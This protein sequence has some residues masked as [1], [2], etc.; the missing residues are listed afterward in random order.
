[1]K[2]SPF[3]FLGVEIDALNIPQLNALVAESIEKQQKQIIANHNLNSLYIYHHDPKMRAFYDKSDYTHI[4]GMPLVFIGKLLGHSIKREE[5]VTYADWVWSLME[6]AAQKSWR[7]FYLGSKPGV[8]EQG[9]NILRQKYPGLEIACA[10]GYIDARKDSH[11]NQATIAAI[12]AFQ[13]DILMVG[14]S[15]PRQEHWILDN[16]ELIQ[17]NAIL[18]SG[19]CMDYVAG[20]VPTP[21]RWMGRIGLEWSYRLF[22]EPKRLWKRY[23]V[24]PWFVVK[25]LIQEILGISN[26]PQTQSNLAFMSHYMATDS[27]KSDLRSA[28][29]AIIQRGFFI[30]LLRV[31]LLMLLDISSLGVAWN[32]A[33]TYASP[34]QSQWTQNLSFLLLSLAVQVAFLAT[35]G[36]YGAGVYRRDYV[37]IVK[38]VSLSSILL[39]FITFIYDPNT[40]IARS[41]FFLY[42]FLCIA[43][44][45]TVRFLF[46]LSTNFLRQKGLMRH[47]IFLIADAQQK[48]Q[49]MKIID[50]DNSYTVQG[51]AESSSLDWAN[52][53]DTFAF[54]RNQNVE[55]VLISWD[56]IKNRSFLC[57]H[58]YNAGITVHI[59]PTE[60]KLPFSKSQLSLIGGLF[61]PKIAAPIFAGFDFRIKRFFDF[62]FSLFVII[63]LSPIYLSIAVLIKLDSPGPI[64]FRQKRIGL[65][66]QEFLIWKFRTMIPNAEKVLASLEGKNEMKDGVFFK[67]KDD[68]RV[69]KVGQFLRRYS[70]DELP[71]FFNVLVGEMSLIGPRPLP[72][73]DVQKFQTKHF[74]RQE[75]LPGITGL[76]QVSGRSN[77]DNFDDV[78]KFDMNYIENWSILLDFSIFLRTFRV[79]LQK[80]GAY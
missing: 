58:F 74:I 79:I 80:T 17:T 27:L 28:K 54:L 11:E 57:W 4:D 51:F 5:R 67:M 36:L 12:N 43:G 56:S 35:T 30:R 24:Q 38:A 31:T 7:I 21:P 78:M 2:R 1:M 15:M 37:S 32:F 34:L 41:T 73:R 53:E 48:E 3:K 14:M 42:W 70:L 19:A 39:S 65:H 16:L 45:C 59:L 22:S 26:Q 75:V 63:L 69:T 62:C 40:Y 10:H 46:D 33:V 9:A 68:P 52:R 55:E 25:L 13:P 66:G 20:V 76:W 64:F 44:I 61:L 8:A 18:P 6:E 72:I 29:R 60:N 77:I 71:Q 50:K 47:S 23:L 49:L